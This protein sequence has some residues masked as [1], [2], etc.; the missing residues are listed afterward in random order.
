MVDGKTNNLR[1]DLFEMAVGYYYG[2]SAQSIDVGKKI[3]IGE[4]LRELD[5]IANYDDFVKVVECKA[6]KAPMT[7][8]EA[9]KWSDKVQLVRE[10][11]SGRDAY[12]EKRHVF[13]LWALGGFDD[14]AKAILEKAATAKKYDFAFFGKD[15]ILSKANKLKDR[16]FLEILKEYFVR[17]P[18]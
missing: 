15:E 11:L 4:L 17:E 3:W 8:E 13:E 16:K 9:Q 2:K 6:G 18:V 1:G 12:E 5:V 14:E 10:W 7:G